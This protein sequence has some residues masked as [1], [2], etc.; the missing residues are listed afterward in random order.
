[1]LVRVPTPTAEQLRLE[2][3]LPQPCPFPPYLG[4]CHVTVTAERPRL[5]GAAP[6]GVVAERPELGGAARPL[7]PARLVLAR[8]GVGRAH[9]RRDPEP[10]RPGRLQR[11]ESLPDAVVERPFDVARNDGVASGGHE[12]RL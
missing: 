6:M 11:F 1:P 7:E 5:P 10:A 8:L 3:C 4:D 2:A 9:E 12:P